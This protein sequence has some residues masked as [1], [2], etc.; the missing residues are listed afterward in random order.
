LESGFVPTSSRMQ[1]FGV[2]ARPK[3]LKNQRCELSFFLFFSFRQ[4]II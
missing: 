4:K 2:K 1:T 3:A